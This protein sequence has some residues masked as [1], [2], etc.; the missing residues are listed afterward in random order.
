MHENL[1]LEECILM[2]ERKLDWGPYGK[3]TAYHFSILSQ[4]IQNK[5]G[6]TVS[7]STLKRLFGK[8][9]TRENYNPQLYTKN[10][11]AE[12]L[13]Y[14]DWQSL[15]AQLKPT[16]PDTI[17]VNKRKTNSVA[18]YIYMGTVIAIILTVL[19]F[20]PQNNSD[21]AWLKTADTS[22]TVPH[23]VVF[24]YDVSKVKDSVFIDFGN[25]TR[26]PLSKEK[27]TITEY[28]K[29][30]GI[31]Y[32]KLLTNKK[33]L[34]SVRICNYSRSWQGGYS[35]NDDYR[36]FIPFEDTS[37][38]WQY[39]RLY[40]PVEYLRLPDPVYNNGIY[41]EYRLMKD[42]SISLDSLEVTAIVKNPSAE[43]GKLCYDIEIW[44]IGTKD[45]CKV[46]FVEPGCYRYGQFKISEKVYN[47]RFDDLSALARD[48]KS[49]KNICIKTSNSKAEIYYNGNVVLTENY[50]NN[51][52]KL[53][54]IYVRFYG[55][56]S[57]Q[58]VR[59]LDH[60]S[61]MI[62]KTNFQKK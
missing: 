48:L 17:K 24:H 60:D 34:D 20:I 29:G 14:K 58:G 52:G 16:T 7:D 15:I 26:I 50:Q 38:F 19:Y 18:V 59:V 46:R 13:E 35:P 21:T 6:K 9:D 37:V 32:P 2:I 49:W 47:G 45:N 23:T 30:C 3:W 4:E 61:R 44:L 57:L 12:Y 5:T 40:T 56:G 22:R 55:T 11:I 31:Y 10:A 41:V 27:H 54:G 51:M 8:K 39:N 1:Y 36:K 53:L 62:Y 33:V 25:N 42:F 28:Y 43:G